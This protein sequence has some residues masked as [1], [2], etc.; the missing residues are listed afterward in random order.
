MAQERQTH[1]PF[2]VSEDDNDI[3]VRPKFNEQLGK[4]EVGDIVTYPYERDSWAFAEVVSV[5]TPFASVSIQPFAVDSQV[6]EYPERF[7]VVQHK[8]IKL[9]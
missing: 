3:V 6:V 7:I 5:N 1:M 4:I 9:Q 8:G 2:I